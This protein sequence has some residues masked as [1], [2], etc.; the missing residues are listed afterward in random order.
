VRSVRRRQS[1][2]RAIHRRMSG[3]VA[4]S[5]SGYTATMSVHQIDNVSTDEGIVDA[6]PRAVGVQRPT[7]PRGGYS[8]ADTCSPPTTWGRWRS[9]TTSRTSI[10]Q[11]TV[12]RR[13]RNLVHHDA[14]DR[15]RRRPGR[16]RLASRLRR[17][18]PVL[19]ADAPATKSRDHHAGDRLVVEP[20]GAGQATTSTT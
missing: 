14:L 11:R 8:R 19:P 20:G 16:K 12:P 7:G 3:S 9:T 15:V 10:R 13:R 1:G 4:Y 6:A 5:H 2:A 18:L 17:F